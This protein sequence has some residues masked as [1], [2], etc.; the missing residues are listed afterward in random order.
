MLLFYIFIQKP[1]NSKD[2]NI[3]TLIAL[4]VEEGEDWKNVKIPTDETSSVVPD[5]SQNSESSQT[6]NLKAVDATRCIVNYIF[7]EMIDI[8][9]FN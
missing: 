4:V 5:L 8:N 6:T 2:V 9:L 3:G 1:D 7:N